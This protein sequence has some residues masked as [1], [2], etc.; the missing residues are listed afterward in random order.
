LCVII[1]LKGASLPFLTFFEEKEYTD[2]ISDYKSRNEIVDK[3][4]ENIHSLLLTFPEEQPGSMHIEKY[5]YRESTGIFAST[6]EILLAYTLND[7][8]FEKEKERIQEIEL[9]TGDTKQSVVYTE[10]GFNYPAYVTAFESEM[11]Y[12]YALI[13][14]ENNRIICVFCQYTD[15]T[16]KDAAPEYLPTSFSPEDMP[17]EIENIYFYNGQLLGKNKMFRM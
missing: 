9:E 17:N 3:A 7:T 8:D 6:Y 5:M 15:E 16:I 2:N 14:E 13:D 1:L 11:V 10:D 12:E 4:Q